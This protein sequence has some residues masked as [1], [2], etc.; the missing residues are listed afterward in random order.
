MIPFI[1][2]TYSKRENSDERYMFSI[3]FLYPL[4]LEKKLMNIQSP[5]T[6]DKTHGET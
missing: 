6:F 1:P 2:K 3:F 4:L 5:D